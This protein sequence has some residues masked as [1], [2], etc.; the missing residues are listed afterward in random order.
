MKDKP[1]TVYVRVSNEECPDV[2]R[3][4]DM[5]FNETYK[6]EGGHMIPFHLWAMFQCELQNMIK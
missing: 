5:Y 1:R 2:D 6:C 3:W 4:K